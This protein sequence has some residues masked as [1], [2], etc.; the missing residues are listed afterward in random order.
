MDKGPEAEESDGDLGMT[1]K[2]CAENKVLNDLCKA[3]DEEYRG[4]D[5]DIRDLDKDELGELALPAE[6]Y[7]KGVRNAL[8]WMA[9][10]IVEK[11]EDIDRSE[12]E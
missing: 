8:S 10:V 12:W 11:T 5:R 6:M 7:L 9:Q 1:S 4:I 2:Q 3:I